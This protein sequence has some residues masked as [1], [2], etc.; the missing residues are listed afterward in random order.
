MTRIPLIH[1]YEKG[2]SGTRR[3]LAFLEK[4]KK[5]NEKE[6]QGFF[7]GTGQNKGG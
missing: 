1:L 6:S 2:E 5:I 7:D 3:S 4:T